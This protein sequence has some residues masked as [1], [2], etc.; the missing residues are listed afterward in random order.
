MIS[1]ILVNEAI[2]RIVSMKDFQVKTDS[3]S[4]QVEGDDDVPEYSA[5]KQSTHFV[6]EEVSN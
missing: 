6:S 3:D 4:S 1:K 5:K 2:D